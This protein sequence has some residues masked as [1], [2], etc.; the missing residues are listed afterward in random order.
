MI[1]AFLG[2]DAKVIIWEINATKDGHDLRVEDQKHHKM[3]E[4]KM[5]SKNY[6]K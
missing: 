4:V 6:I 2:N 3:Y 1:N 5:D